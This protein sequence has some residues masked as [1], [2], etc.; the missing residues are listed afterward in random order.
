MLLTLALQDDGEA[1]AAHEEGRREQATHTN[2]AKACRRPDAC[3][4]G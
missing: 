3:A 1:C 4:T 2:M